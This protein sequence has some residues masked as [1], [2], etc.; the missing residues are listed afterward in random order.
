MDPI[1]MA[2]LCNVLTITRHQRGCQYRD[3]KSERNE[4]IPVNNNWLTNLLN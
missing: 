1:R 3:L 2:I 4:G